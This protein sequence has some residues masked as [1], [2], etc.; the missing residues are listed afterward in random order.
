MGMCVLVLSYKK[1]NI[2]GRLCPPS[3]GSLQINNFYVF[4]YKSKIH[5]RR[6]KGKCDILITLSNNEYK[7]YTTELLGE[8]TEVEFYSYIFLISGLEKSIELF[9]SQRLEYLVARKGG[10][11]KMEK[12]FRKS[13]MPTYIRTKVQFS[14]K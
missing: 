3:Q 8:T 9:N 4:H 14:I 7:A 6:E 1:P 10:E 11:A 13:K 12:P 5:S 2:G